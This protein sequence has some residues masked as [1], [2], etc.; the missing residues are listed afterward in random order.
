MGLGTHLSV[1]QYWSKCGCAREHVAASED[2]AGSAGE[3]VNKVGAGRW[4]CVSLRA[5]PQEELPVGGSGESWPAAG[6]TVGLGALRGWD[7]CVCLFVSMGK[8]AVG[9]GTGG[10]GESQ[11]ALCDGLYQQLELGWSL[12]GS[13]AWPK[14]RAGWSWWCEHSVCL[15]MIGVASGVYVQCVH[16]PAGSSFS[17]CYWLDLGMELRLPHLSR[18]SDPVW[19]IFS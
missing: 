17:A 3:W 19:S 8:T 12:R 7:T 9:L 11:P 6:E 13:Y 14:R 1:L 2:Q 5:R 4:A 10:P 18:L 15:S 16:L